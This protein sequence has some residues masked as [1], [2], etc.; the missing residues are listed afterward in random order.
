MS[1]VR[2]FGVRDARLSGRDTHE[3]HQALER[4]QDLLAE[5]RIAVIYGGDHEC[6][7]AVIRR[8]SNPRSWKSYIAVAE[9]IAGALRRLGVGDVCLLP[10]DM[11]LGERLRDSNIDLAWLNTAGV[12]GYHAA[13]HTAAVAIS[14]ATDMLAQ[15]CFTAWNMAIGRP[16]CSRSRA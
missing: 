16:N 4:A 14:V 6:E 3:Q 11:R 7:G 8:T 13:S 5:L 9:D 1:V 10:D 2:Y 15:W 12:Q